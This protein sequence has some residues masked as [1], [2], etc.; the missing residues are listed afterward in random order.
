MH[1][2]INNDR[3]ISTGFQELH[4]LLSFSRHRRPSRSGLGILFQPA[5]IHSAESKI[6]LLQAP[7]RSALYCV[8]LPFNYDKFQVLD[9]ALIP[10]LDKSVR[11]GF[12]WNPRQL[13]ALERFI[14]AE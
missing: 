3:D 11:K 10:D 14:D 6:N 4:D 12:H 7:A 5:Q 9:Q 8:T 2:P 13:V 1:L